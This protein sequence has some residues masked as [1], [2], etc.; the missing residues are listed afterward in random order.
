MF[1]VL[2]F[3][4]HG[5]GKQLSVFKFKLLLASYCVLLKIANF[6]RISLGNYRSLNTIIRVLTKQQQNNYQWRKKIS[7]ITKINSGYEHVTIVT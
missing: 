2:S 4:A 1:T 7:L 6:K 3:L 5:R